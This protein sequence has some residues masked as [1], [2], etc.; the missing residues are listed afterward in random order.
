MD[1]EDYPEIIVIDTE[2]V[3]MAKYAR[4]QLEITTV[5][6]ISAHTSVRYRNMVAQV[7]NGTSTDS[8]D[9]AGLPTKALRFYWGKHNVWTQRQ[10]L[11][12]FTVDL[13]LLCIVIVTRI[14]DGVHGT[15]LRQYN[16]HVCF[17]FL[18]CIRRGKLPPPDKA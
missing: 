16:P 13:E 12:E 11:A 9:N 14:S 3:D 8:L 4:H 2:A 10:L 18:P 6:P 7:F 1:P 17:D 15:M 5:P